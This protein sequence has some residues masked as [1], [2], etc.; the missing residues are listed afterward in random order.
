[1]N[2]QRMN[3]R[4]FLK[5]AALMALGV[6]ALA[7]DMIGCV[8]VAGPEP[9]RMTLDISK[10]PYTALTAV[11]GG[12]KITVPGQTHPVMVTRT[13]QTTVAAF[14]SRCTHQGCDVGLPSP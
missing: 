13:T 1:M 5:K 11:N 6:N 9:Q 10:S 8:K 4:K 14:S 3:R 7:T 12:V 2:V